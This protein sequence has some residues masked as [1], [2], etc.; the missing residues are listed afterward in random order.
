MPEDQIN[1]MAR[2]VRCLG[3][4]PVHAVNS[5]FTSSVD[6]NSYVTDCGRTL[7]VAGGAVLTTRSVT[8]RG[9]L[10]TQVLL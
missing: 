4:G 8:C 1:R 6:G 5:T 10:R 3:R 7:S 2:Q 9:C